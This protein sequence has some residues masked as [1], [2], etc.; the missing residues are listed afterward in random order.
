MELD[1]QYLINLIELDYRKIE[2]NLVV[3]K[4][5]DLRPEDYK[6]IENHYQT[7]LEKASKQ[8]DILNNIK[9]DALHGQSLSVCNESREGQASFP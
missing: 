2:K 6:V 8:I 9:M 3:L 1:R 7:R 4:F 5:M